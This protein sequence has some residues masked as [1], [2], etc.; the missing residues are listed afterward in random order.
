MIRTFLKEEGERKNKEPAMF[1]SSSFFKKQTWR[2]KRFCVCLFHFP[3][4]SHCSR[5]CIKGR[6]NLNRQSRKQCMRQMKVLYFNWLGILH[7]L[8]FNHFL[9]LLVVQFWFGFVISFFFS[10]TNL[11]SNLI[12]ILIFSLINKT[13]I[14]RQKLNF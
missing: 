3:F 12:E 6:R 10:I 1:F 4:R 2:K 7:L 13:I 8:K 14:I 5:F 11:I 9:N